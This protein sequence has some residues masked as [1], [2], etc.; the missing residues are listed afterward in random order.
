MQLSPQKELSRWL[1]GWPNKLTFLRILS[2]P[3][4]ILLH[5]LD[6]N[7]VRIIIAFVFLAAALTDFFDG[8]LARR[9]GED[10]IEGALLDPIADKML[11][12][13]GLVLLVAA[14]QLYAWVA[15]LLI[16]REIAVSG[17]RLLA[18]EK[19]IH[20][21]VNYLGKV[22]TVSQVFTIFC[23]LM[24]NTGFEFPY[25][26]IGMLSLWFTL[27]ISLYSGY[28]YSKDFWD[29]LRIS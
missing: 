6:F 28:Q 29:K 17:I 1:K 27:G 23:L 7:I 19:N 24:H 8:Y 13:T 15:I 21:E 16:C 12:I 3:L 5:P 14:D 2:I 25:R 20:I 10:S 4:L 9:S 11:I 18:L 26:T 22:K